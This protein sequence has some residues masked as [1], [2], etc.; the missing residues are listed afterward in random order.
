MTFRDKVF[1]AEVLDQNLKVKR[2]WRLKTLK[3]T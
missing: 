1:F 3:A 2:I